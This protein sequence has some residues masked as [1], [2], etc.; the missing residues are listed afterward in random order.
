MKNDLQEFIDKH[1]NTQ[2][3]SNISEKRIFKMFIEL[4]Q[5][6]KV[7]L[8]KPDELPVI[9]VDVRGGIAYCKD[10]RVKIIDHD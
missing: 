4:A 1:S 6:I 7:E 3:Y 8:G 2:M 9:V 10:K 5:A